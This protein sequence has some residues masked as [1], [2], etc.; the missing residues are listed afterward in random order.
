MLESQL[1]SKII[2]YAE[3]KGVLSIKHMKCNLNG[4][5]D[6]QLIFP[7][8]WVLFFECKTSSGKLS[9]VQKKMI[10]KLKHCFQQ[11][12]VV[13]SYDEAKNLIDSYLN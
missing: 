5:P 1:Q 2:K 7:V 10:A 11:V 3:S 6:L 12:Y 9:V 13:Y 4:I 8:G